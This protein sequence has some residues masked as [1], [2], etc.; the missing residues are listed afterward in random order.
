MSMWCFSH[1]LYTIQGRKPKV[2]GPQSNPLNCG[3]QFCPNSVV[4]QYSLA[5][6]P[7]HWAKVEAITS[8]LLWFSQSTGFVFPLRQFP[9]MESQALITFPTNRILGRTHPR[10]G[11]W[12]KVKAITS[13]LHGG[14]IKKLQTFVK[15][16]WKEVP[17][18]E[19]WWE[20]AMGGALVLRREENLEAF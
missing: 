18:G 4:I 2:Q 7:P 16:G 17:E 11:I 8:L 10:I 1:D 13:K 3:T 14:S 20:E 12:N 9:L 5:N 19:R 15:G 6:P